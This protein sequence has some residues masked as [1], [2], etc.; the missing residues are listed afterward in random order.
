MARVYEM[1]GGP[2]MKFLQQL[3]K[4]IHK[5][6]ETAQVNISLQFAVGEE[7]APAVKEAGYD[8][9][10][11]VKIFNEADRKG[12]SPDARLLIDKTVWDNASVDEREGMLDHLLQR[13]EARK[14]E[15]G[16]IIRDSSGRP[17]LNRRKYDMRMNGFSTVIERNGEH[18]PESKQWKGILDDHGQLLMWS[19]E[20][21]SVG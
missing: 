4:K 17:K 20:P 9:F 16:E 10:G 5:E 1:A 6:L 3:V 19:K 7:G 15:K 18:A 21:A 2:E 12:G 14:T 13:L 11:K 8:T